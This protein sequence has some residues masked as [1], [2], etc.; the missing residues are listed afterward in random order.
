MARGRFLV[1]CESR[2]CGSGSRVKSLEDEPIAS[3]L[4]EHAPTPS[5]DD[6]KE[7][8]TDVPRLGRQFSIASK[9]EQN[10]GI[11]HV[12]IL[13]CIVSSYYGKVIFSYSKSNIMILILMQT[14]GE[15][16]LIIL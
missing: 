2:S 3:P 15:Y 5:L 9:T 6:V 13:R 12:N 14:W 8:H 11:V 10:I 1:R 16:V 4:D 7:P